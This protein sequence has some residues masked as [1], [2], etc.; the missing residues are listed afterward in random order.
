MSKADG[1]HQPVLAGEAVGYLV[2]RPDGAYIDATSGGGSHTVLIL[3]KLQSSGKVLAIDRDEEAVARTQS[4]VERFSSQVK[5]VRG[6]FAELRELTFEA[7][8]TSVNGILFDLGVSS[9]QL[10]SPRRG[11]SYRASGPLDFRMDNRGTLTA[12]DVINSYPAEKLA[13][14]FFEFGEEKNSRKIAAAIVAA[15]KKAP[16]ITTGELAAVI[17]SVTNPR[18]VNKTLSRVFQSLRVVIND[19]INQLQRGLNA[20]VELLSSQGRL[21]VIAYHSLEDRIAK[22]FLR[23]QAAGKTNYT[24][25]AENRESPALKVIT[26][27]PIMATPEEIKDNPRARSAR[28][29][30]GEKI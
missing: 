7:G 16:L 9:H 14:I 3:S 19:E 18:W 15:R 22:N 27:K 30:V 29:R 21:V 13:Q 10:D 5:V 8:M 26:K 12:A 6:E 1:Y 11:F 25:D 2:T 17:T 24:I 4:R 20:A 28:L 23:D